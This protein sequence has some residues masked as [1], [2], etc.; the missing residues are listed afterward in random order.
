[1]P[2]D[3]RDDIVFDK[4]RYF[5]GCY[6]KAKSQRFQNSSGLNM[7]QQ[8]LTEAAACSRLS[9]VEDERK[10]KEDER[11]KKRGKTHLSSPS[12]FSRALFFA[13]PHRSRGSTLKVTA[14]PEYEEKVRNRQSSY[15]FHLESNLFF[16]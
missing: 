2:H 5:T 12:F 16:T 7:S 6:T 9:E 14:P 8:T 13:H 4:R 15:L 1:M 11:E 3:Y 10:K